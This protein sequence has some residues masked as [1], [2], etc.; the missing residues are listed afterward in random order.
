MEDI[1]RLIMAY[2]RWRTY[3]NLLKGGTDRHTQTDRCKD[4]AIYRLN[5]PRG[6]LNEEKNHVDNSINLLYVKSNC[7]I[8][9]H[10]FAVC[11]VKFKS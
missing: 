9:L 3:I 8:L 1:D 2:Y 5:E 6:W 7:M 10:T 4:I 11:V